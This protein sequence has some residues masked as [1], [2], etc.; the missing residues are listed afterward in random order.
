MF[1]IRSAVSRKDEYRDTLVDRGAT[2]GANCTIVCGIRI[3]RYAFI[4]AGAVVN[5]VKP[6]ALM[7]GVPARQMGWM[8]AHGE[9]VGLPL[10]GQGEWICPKAAIA[11]R[12]RRSA[13]SHTSARS[14]MQ[15]IDLKAQQRQRLADG[16]S[17]RVAIDGRIAVLDHGLCILGP[18]VAELEQRLAAYVGVEHCVACL[19]APTPC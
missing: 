6:F 10:G 7:V 3:G 9:R 12:C 18:E 19:A 17:L 11:I 14:L 15:F 13:S 16:S 1:T 2:L 8:S 5:S 4:G